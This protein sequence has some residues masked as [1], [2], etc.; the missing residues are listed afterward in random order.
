MSDTKLAAKRLQIEPT[1]LF[2]DDQGNTVDPKLF[3]L[4]QALYQHKKLTQA[5]AA[6]GIS[7]R[8]AWNLLNKWAEFFGAELVSLHKGRGA[9]L[10]ALGE[11]LLWA[12]QR[13]VARFQPQM[14]S[15]ASELNIE[16]QAALAQT[17]P[18]LRIQ[19]SHG[20]AVALLPKA[21]THLQLDLQYR[22]AA[23]ALA[24]LNR[25]AC[26]LAGLHIPR[27]IALPELQQRYRALVKP[28]S[29]RMIRFISR[30]QGLIVAKGNPKNVQGLEDLARPQLR[31]I[32]RQPDSGTRALIDQMLGQVRIDKQQLTGYDNQEFTH[33]AV[34][35]HVA[36][37]MADIGFGVRHAAHLFGLDFIPLCEEDYVFICHKQTLANAA[38]ESFIKAIQTSAFKHEVSQLAGY[39]AVE[40]GLISALDEWITDA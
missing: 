9:N 37:G 32:N 31:F 14:E 20:Y 7:Y 25:G 29:L 16:I 11:K 40:S 21:C 1:W 33:S 12:E 24:A 18:Q 30:Q 23:E 5:A 35:A 3:T 34:A 26:D 22:S 8:H 28:R 19:A 36:S 4:L 38:L 15:L 17:V 10:T 13:V 6:A 27:G 2:R 39:Q